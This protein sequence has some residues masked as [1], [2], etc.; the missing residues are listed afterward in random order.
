M[1]SIELANKLINLPKQLKGGSL[2][3]NL[4]Q[5]K[6]RLILSNDDEPDYSFLFEITSHKK[7]SFKISLHNQ[8]NNSKEGLMRVDY[9]G[10]HKNPEGINDFV[11]DIVK[12]YVGYFFQNEPHI[13]IYVEG[14]KDLAWAIPLSAYNF[15]ILD[16][17]STDDFRDAINAFAKEINIITP[18]Y[19]QNALL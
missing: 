9:K 3:I 10:G 19:I 5:E 4:S 12:P 14:F 1:F 2:T 13:H 15:P 16:I 7:I 6:S 8:E 11:P 17:N 18:I